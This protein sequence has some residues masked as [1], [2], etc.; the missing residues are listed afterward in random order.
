MS[1]WWVP[2]RLGSSAGS[3]G[4]GVCLTNGVG[5]HVPALDLVVEDLEVSQSRCHTA[6]LHGVIASTRVEV[7]YIQSADPMKYPRRPGH[8][9]AE[10]VDPAVLE[11]RDDRQTR[12]FSPRPG[13]PGRR[14]QKP[15]TMRSTWTPARAAS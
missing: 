4:S 7:A 14:Q 13:T 1:S 15:R 8:R 9:H 5:K 2:R 6:P 10:P 12:M 11:D 3:P